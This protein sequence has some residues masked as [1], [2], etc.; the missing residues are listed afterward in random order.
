MSELVT[1]GAKQ[2]PMTLL[3]FNLK[4][5]CR[6]RGLSVLD[7]AGEKTGRVSIDCSIASV[8]N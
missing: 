8:I 2:A 3:P 6:W 4:L 1:L 5:R 7:K